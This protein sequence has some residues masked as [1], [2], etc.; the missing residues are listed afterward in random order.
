MRTTLDIDD[1]VLQAAKERARREAKTAGQVISELAR[2]ALTA[3]VAAVVVR[4]QAPVYGLRPFPA[5]GEIVTNAI[6][7]QLRAG[8]GI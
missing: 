6:I 3:P 2:Q 8:D 4:E 7:D 1:D 5:T